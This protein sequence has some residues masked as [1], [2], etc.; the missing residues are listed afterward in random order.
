[1]RLLHDLS[2]SRNRLNRTI[3]P[4]DSMRDPKYPDQYYDIGARALDLVLFASELCDKPHFP[5]ILDLPS[6]Y[7][8][9]LR[10][11]RAHY[12]YAEITACDLERPGVDFCAAEFGAQPVYS[13]PDLAQVKFA[14]PFDLIWVGSLF[15]HLDRDRWLS[16]L[17]QLIAL[18]AECG[19]L[20]F[21][22]HG[23][24]FT[25]LLS[26]GRP[27][28]AGDVDV[29]ALLSKYGRNGFAYE[30]Y[31]SSADGSYGVSA[32]SGAWLQDVLQSRNDVIMRAYLEEA[33]GMQDV[34]VLYKASR[35][36]ESAATLAKA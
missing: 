14:Q 34:V 8:R 24:C 25:T 10:W 33:W 4:L 20:I 18:T 2:H 30:P 3:S 17:D 12:D 35:Y 32:T 36:Y 11:L 1:M 22:T 19:I 29:A 7:G 5:R 23:R 15:T 13:Q 31:R 28:L 27:E 26:R 21:T 6:G 16:T 9:V